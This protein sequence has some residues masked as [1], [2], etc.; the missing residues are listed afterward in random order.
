MFF[1]E[2]HAQREKKFGNRLP[3]PDLDFDSL[4]RPQGD[5]S[6]CQ[7]VVPLPLILFN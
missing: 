3:L 4:G 5:V 7:V 2:F 1:E 6:F